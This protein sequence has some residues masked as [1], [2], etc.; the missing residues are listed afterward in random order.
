[1][2]NNH[3]TK[4]ISDTSTISTPETKR[5][6]NQNKTVEVLDQKWR[7]YLHHQADISTDNLK[8]PAQISKSG[9]SGDVGGIFRLSSKDSMNSL[10]LTLLSIHKMLNL[11]F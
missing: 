10:K 4:D 5:T 1:M 2:A 8:I 6:Q 9:G 7:Y 11:L 3:H